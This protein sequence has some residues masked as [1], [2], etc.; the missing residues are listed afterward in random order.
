MHLS[1]SYN[2]NAAAILSKWKLTA[3]AVLQKKLCCWT[4]F[5][6]LPFRSNPKGENIFKQQFSGM[7]G[8][9]HC[10]HYLIYPQIATL[11]GIKGS[12]KIIISLK[13]LNYLTSLVV[14]DLV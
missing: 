8:A 14:P 3:E 7:Q 11:Q 13:L 12:W 2:T 9:A 1:P 10:D 5:S 4:S 6:S